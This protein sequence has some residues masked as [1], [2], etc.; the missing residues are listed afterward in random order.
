V[1]ASQFLASPLQ[2]WKRFKRQARFRN[3]PQSDAKRARVNELLV[4]AD[5]EAIAPRLIKVAAARIRLTFGENSGGLAPDGMAP[6]EFVHDA[7]I[8][9]RDGTRTWDPD[10]YDLEKTLMLAVLS[11]VDT[12]AV[13]TWR[14]LK[15][16]RNLEHE[17][18]MSHPE[19]LLGKPHD[20]STPD[21][22][23]EYRESRREWLER[24]KDRPLAQ[25]MAQLA[26]DEGIDEPATLALRLKV[27]RKKIY[28]EMKWLRR[29]LRSTLE[30]EAR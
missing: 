14:R 23:L 21:A 20:P 1:K 26:I 2:L 3:E 18:A 28:N 12:H 19:P 13:L 7:I 5:W 16:E 11:E 17:Y 8:K 4:N 27:S 30:R 9:F 24:F 25:R 10:R 15:K 29:Q 6:E 22:L